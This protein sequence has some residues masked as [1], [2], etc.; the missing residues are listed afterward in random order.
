VGF[1]T[2]ENDGDEPIERCGPEHRAAVFVEKPREMEWGETPDEAGEGDGQC[3]S[4]GVEAAVEGR[5]HVRVLHDG[6]RLWGWMRQLP[7]ATATIKA[8]IEADSLGECKT[9]KATTTAKA[10]GAGFLRSHISKARCGAPGCEPSLRM[11]RFVVMR[12]NSNSQYSGPFPLASLRVRM[13]NQKKRMTDFG[14]VG[15]RGR[16]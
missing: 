3:E 10:R 6:S 13:T 14:E 4:Q 2:R 1:E 9:R 12:A 11:T 7:A 8:T 15:E 5:G 16:A